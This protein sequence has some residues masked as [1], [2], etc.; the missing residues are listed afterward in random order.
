[1][2]FMLLFFYAH[3]NNYIKVNETYIAELVMD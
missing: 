2:V 3:K 1:M